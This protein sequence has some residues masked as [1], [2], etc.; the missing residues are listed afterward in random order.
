MNCGS[1]YFF[2]NDIWHCTKRKLDISGEL[3]PDYWAV[4]EDIKNYWDGKED[5]SPG[6][7]LRGQYAQNVA[8]VMNQFFGLVE[9]RRKENPNGQTVCATFMD[10]HPLDL[11]QRWSNKPVG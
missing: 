10:L 2:Y 8:P 4:L 9:D 11:M 1:V 5:M 7:V 6:A 3:I